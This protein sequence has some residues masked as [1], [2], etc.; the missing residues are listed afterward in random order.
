MDR[1]GKRGLT[2][3]LALSLL[4]GLL[5]GCGKKDNAQQLSANVYVPKYLDIGLDVDYIQ[6]GCTDGESIYLIGQKDT[7]RERQDS[8]SGEKYVY[9][10]SRY[11]IYRVS[12]DGETAERLPNYIGPSVPEGKEGNAYIEDIQTGADG[13]IWVREITYVWGDIIDRKSVV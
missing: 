13:T 1:F 10:E 11:D 3:L 12:L 8:A 6:R 9:T 2:L 7:T 4:L 5:A